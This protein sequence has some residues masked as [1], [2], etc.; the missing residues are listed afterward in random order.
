MDSVEFVHLAGKSFRDAAKTQNGKTTENAQNPDDYRPSANP[1]WT[2][3][4]LPVYI[5]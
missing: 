5:R 1:L 2:F 4:Q 3:L